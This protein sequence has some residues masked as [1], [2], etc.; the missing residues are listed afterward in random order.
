MRELRGRGVA[1]EL[2]KMRSLHF[3]HCI[4]KDI[5]SALIG[6]LLWGIKISSYNGK[7]KK[8]VWFD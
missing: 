4:Q 6:I 5:A 7:G 1:N 8:G 3:Q 2:Q